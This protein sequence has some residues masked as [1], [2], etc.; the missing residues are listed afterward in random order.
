MRVR[1]REVSR[2]DPQPACFANGEGSLM[3]QGPLD[4]AQM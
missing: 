2:M 1:E 3:R 4:E